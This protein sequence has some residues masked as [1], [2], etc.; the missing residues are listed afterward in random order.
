MPSNESGTVTDNAFVPK[1]LGATPTASRR[2]GYGA[3]DEV[4]GSSSREL[5]W[6]VLRLLVP[7]DA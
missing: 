5:E 2:G 4:T 3:A 1:L 7:T 6:I